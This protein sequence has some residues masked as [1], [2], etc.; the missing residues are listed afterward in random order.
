MA[1]ANKKAAG[2][3]TK[4][5]KVTARAASFWRG[6]HQFGAEPKTLALSDLSPEQAELI[7]TEG[8]PGGMLVVEEVEIEAPAKA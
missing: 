5:L 6:N 7:R 2:P 1:T 8:R 3:A 4:G